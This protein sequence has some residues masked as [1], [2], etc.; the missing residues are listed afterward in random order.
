MNVLIDPGSTHSYVN[1]AYVCHLGW[2]EAELPYTLLV[3]IQ[4]GKS[5]EVVRGRL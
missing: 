5:I 4:L 1:E 2:D 3:S